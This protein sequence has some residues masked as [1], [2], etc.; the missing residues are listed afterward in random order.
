MRS[1]DKDIRGREKTDTGREFMSLSIEK[2]ERV[3]SLVTSC[4]SVVDRIGTRVRK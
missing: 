3:M 4:I 1:K 2:V